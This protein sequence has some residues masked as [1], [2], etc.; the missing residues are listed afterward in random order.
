MNLLDLQHEVREKLRYESYRSMHDIAR[1]TGLHF[2]TIKRYRT[3]AIAGQ[4]FYT[5]AKLAEYYG[6]QTVT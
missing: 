1:E 6:Y 2:A 3:G 4:K 5:V